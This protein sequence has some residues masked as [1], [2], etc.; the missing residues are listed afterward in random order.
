MQNQKL[1]KQKAKLNEFEAES[2]NQKYPDEKVELLLFL[3]FA[4]E[5]LRFDF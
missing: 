5:I 3:F 1:G 4:F 2:L